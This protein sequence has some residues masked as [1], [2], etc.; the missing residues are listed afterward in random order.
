MLRN[1]PL[2]GFKIHKKIDISLRKFGTTFYQYECSTRAYKNCKQ[3]KESFCIKHG[4]DRS[5]VKASFAK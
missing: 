3:A 2:V 5:Q 1:I 4:L